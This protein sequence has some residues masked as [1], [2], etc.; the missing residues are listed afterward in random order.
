MSRKRTLAARV[1]G[2]ILACFAY[3]AKAQQMPFDA[4]ALAK[5]V[6]AATN[7][8]RAANGLPPL[9]AN[10]AL[11][12]AASAYAR[13]L[14]ENNAFGHTAD[15]KDPAKRVT[16]QGYRFC[17]VAENVWGGWRTPKPFTLGE[18][19]RRSMEGWKKSPG[20]NANLLCT[21]SRNI[22]IGATAWTHDGRI[23]FRVVQNFGAEC[24]VEKHPKPPKKHS[25]L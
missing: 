4:T 13:F 3:C 6:T 8:Y 18:V 9:T 12:R 23:I 15:G 19:A 7:A 20:H 2:L 24:P 5:E 17:H 16:A 21:S 25:P 22:G 14:A 11:K 10:A 1:S